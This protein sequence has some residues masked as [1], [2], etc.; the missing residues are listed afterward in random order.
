LQQL[1]PVG[2]PAYHRPFVIG[3][4]GMF[5]GS[6]VAIVTP[7]QADSAVDFAALEKL[8]EFHVEAGTSGLVVAGTTG[9]S[10]TLTKTEHVAV[11]EATVNMAAGR[12][13]VFSGTRSN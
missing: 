11:I 9:E 7:M 12:V 6:L 3:A 10:A 1:A 2:A 5:K 8:I 13:A 4:E